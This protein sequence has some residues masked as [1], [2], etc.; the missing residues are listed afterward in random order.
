MSALKLPVCI[1]SILLSVVLWAQILVNQG[2]TTETGHAVFTVA[3]MLTSGIIGL[4]AKHSKV[5]HAIVGVF[6]SIGGI[7]GLV[8]V[9][10]FPGF[11][12]W[13]MLCFVFAGIFFSL[14][15]RD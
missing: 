6:H 8:T 3:A 5:S 10:D 1:F 11:L 4:I 15:R 2:G 13:S 9:R 14:S 7:S 12:M